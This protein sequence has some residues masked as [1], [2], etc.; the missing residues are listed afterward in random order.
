VC[1]VLRSEKSDDYAV[2]AHFN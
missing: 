1:A 2:V